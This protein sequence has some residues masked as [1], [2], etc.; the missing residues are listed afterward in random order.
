VAKEG[1]YVASETTGHVLASWYALDGWDDSGWFTDLN[2]SA[3]SV[4]VVVNYYSGPGALPEQLW[5]LNPPADR[6]VGFSPTYNR[7]WG[8]EG[9]IARGDWHAMEVAWP[10]AEEMVP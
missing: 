10:V 2:L 4:Y 5:I 8:W 7:H 6:V 1:L 9:A 3:P